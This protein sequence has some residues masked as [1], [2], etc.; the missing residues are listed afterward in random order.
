MLGHERFYQDAELYDLAFSYRDYA[1]EA[2][3]LRDVC[4]TFRHGAA[5]ERF[6]ELAAGPAHHALEMIAHGTPSV[7][8]DHSR[9]M[10]RYG[11]RLARERQVKLP[12]LVAN[13]ESFKLDRKFDLAASMGCSATYL[14]DDAAVDRHLAAVAAVLV[15]EGVYV[16]EL[17]YP[18]ELE[19]QTQWEV[20][21]PEGRLRVEWSEVRHPAAA[22]YRHAATRAVLAFQPRRGR[23]K[24]TEVTSVQRFFTVEEVRAAAERSGELTLEA[25]YGAHDRRVKLDDERAW[26][27]LC[28]LCKR[29]PA[30]REERVRL[31]ATG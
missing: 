5:P 13:M 25:V 28:V 7:A 1:Q 22:G 9:P 3:F 31:L 17:P 10:K 11:L 2:A 6:L 24:R 26:R 16:L 30:V 19:A 15:P 4:K 14:L 27:M 20:A 18:A 12:Y 8:L 21:S 29:V 23:E